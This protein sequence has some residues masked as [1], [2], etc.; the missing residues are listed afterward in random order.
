[1]GLLRR[2]RRAQG[3]AQVLAAVAY[4]GSAVDT[5]SAADAVER[6]TATEQETAR[7]AAIHQAEFD[8]MAERLL[9]L[10]AELSDYIDR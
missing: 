7:L 6:L 5:R 9:A 8:A 2:V 10:Q 4:E 1:M 3:A